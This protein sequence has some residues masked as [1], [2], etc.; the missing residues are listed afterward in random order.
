[1]QLPSLPLSI[2]SWSLL[3]LHFCSASPFSLDFFAKSLLEVEIEVNIAEF[4]SSLTLL[5][6]LAFK[7]LERTDNGGF[8][9]NPIGF[10]PL[11]ME[12]QLPTP[13]GPVVGGDWRVQLQDDSRE[14]IV[15][16]M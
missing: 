8:W 2:Y 3:L 9:I 1:M 6:F 12:G 5:Y 15:S 11:E 10:R 14:R 7:L 4:Q 16:K 13:P